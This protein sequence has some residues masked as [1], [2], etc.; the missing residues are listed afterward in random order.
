MGDNLL[1][2]VG[3]GRHGGK[4]NSKGKIQKGK[5][6]CVNLAFSFLCGEKKGKFKREKI[7]AQTWRPLFSAVRKKCDSS[8]GRNRNNFFLKT[9]NHRI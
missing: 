1:E 3:D 4:D 6:L 9:K 8:K 2:V 5:N 7:S